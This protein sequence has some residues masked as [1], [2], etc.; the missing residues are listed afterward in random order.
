[1]KTVTTPTENELRLANSVRRAHDAKFSLDEQKNP[2]V[3]SFFEL[4]G[5]H[6]RGRIGDSMLVAGHTSTLMA[7]GYIR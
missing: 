4:R 7:C 3:Q 5:L 6:R 2:E 1:M